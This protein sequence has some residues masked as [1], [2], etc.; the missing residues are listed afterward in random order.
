M[1]YKM[2]KRTRNRL[3]LGSG[4]LALLVLVMG[5]VLLVRSNN[6]EIV[7]NGEATTTVEVFDPYVDLEAKVVYKSREIKVLKA[8][9]SNLDTQVIGDYTITY[10]HKSFLMKKVAKRHIKVVDTT[11][12]EI[13]LK[14]SDMNLKLNQ[15]FS[16]PGYQASD[17]YDGDIS[18]RVTVVGHVDTSKLGSYVLTYSVTDT[19]GNICEVKRKVSITE[20]AKP[21]PPKNPSAGIIYLTFDDG[22]HATN[23]DIILD[24]LKSEGVKATFFV[25]GV[26][27][28]RVI[29]RAYDEGHELALHTYSHRY[30]EIYK[31]DEAYFSDLYKIQARIKNI[32]GHTTMLMRFPGGS[33]NNISRKLN[34][35]IMTRLTKSVQAKGFK[36]FDWNVDS[37]DASY[38][39][40][41]N[42]VYNNT[43]QQLSK[44]RSNVIL[45]HDIHTH[46]SDALRDIIQYGK[47]N[48]Y[49]FEVLSQLEGSV[50]HNV[51]N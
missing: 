3:I 41:G 43:I 2:R 29:K 22:P 37:G 34:Q 31:D 11:A 21:I 39:V 15:T 24:I 9:D 25:V 46:T 35:G 12:P 32:T 50:H 49:T 48:G 13:K 26:G 18:D 19:S 51:N 23:T 20:I 28:D 1:G 47:K 6:T 36:Y 33:S 10:Q 7:I 4:V 30:E 45:M 40:D 16:D 42:F 27:P 17:N 8:K 14:G 38:S 5:I 44:T